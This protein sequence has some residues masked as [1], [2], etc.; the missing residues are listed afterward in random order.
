[1]RCRAS[2]SAA[3]APTPAILAFYITSPGNTIRGLAIGNVYRAIF[4]D[5]ADAHDNRIVGN[6][7]GFTRTGA[8]VELGQLRDPAEHRAPT[9]T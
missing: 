4:L 3:T 9:T 1:M 5:G 2:K 8:N 6:W 7:I